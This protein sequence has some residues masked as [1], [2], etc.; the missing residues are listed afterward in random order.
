MKSVIKLLY[1]NY[2]NFDIIRSG[3]SARKSKKAH[4]SG[5]EW[6]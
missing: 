1:K 5:H 2:Y 3:V 4:L 6:T